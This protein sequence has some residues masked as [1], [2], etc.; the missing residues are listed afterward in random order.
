MQHTLANHVGKFDN[1][2]HILY[3]EDSDIVRESTYELLK[4]FFPSIDL[5]V[6][7]VD[8]LEKYETYYKKV[9]V[10]YDIVFTDINMPRLN[11]IKMSEQILKNHPLQNIVIISAHNEVDYLLT[12]INLGISYFVLKPI[13]NIPFKHTVTRLIHSIENEKKLKQKQ[14]ELVKMNTL[15]QRAKKRAE[16]ASLNKSQFLAHMSHE[17]RTPLNAV[18]G[19]ISILS[20]MEKDPLKQRY[21]GIINNASDTLLKII[22]DLLDVSKIE[23]GKMLLKNETFSPFNALFLT[24]ELFQAQ[25]REAGV[26]LKIVYKKSLPKYLYGDID[27]IKQIFSNLLSN[28]IKFTPQNAKIK[29]VIGY[30]KGNLMIRVKD[31]GIGISKE[32][33]SAIFEPFS[34]AEVPMEHSYR[35]TGL[36]LAISQQL[37]QHMQGTLTLKSKEGEGS[38]FTLLLPLKEVDADASEKLEE[39]I[40]DAVLQGKHILI[41]EDSQTSSMFLAILFENLGIHCDI[42]VNG[43]EAIEKFTHRK[44]DLILMDETMPKL[45]GT[46]AAKEILSIEK[47]SGLQHTP[48]IAL[49]AHV[50]NDDNLTFAPK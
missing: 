45:S 31:H 2:L 8:G 7:G 15:L 1:D 21:L 12:S 19:F 49:T 18:V 29:C 6:D 33:Q 3:V 24:G 26:S 39:E 35:G 46:D 5:A 40:P 32:R 38:I 30:K 16:E 27:K 13:E 34:Q 44:Y 37:T 22:S 25:A 14:T 36:G 10:R 20:E 42:V 41:V 28:A 23:S 43:L 9:G 47:E 17:I 48:I 4:E 11:G 50:L